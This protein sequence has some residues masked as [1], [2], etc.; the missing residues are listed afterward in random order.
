MRRS[1]DNQKFKDDQNKRRK[2]SRNRRKKE[3]SKG[4]AQYEIEAQIKRRRL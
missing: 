4:F 1:V 3:D 2:I